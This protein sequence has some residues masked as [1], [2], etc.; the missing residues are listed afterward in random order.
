MRPMLQDLR[1]GLRM[2]VKQPGFTAIAA[3]TLALGI[4]ANTAI[5]SVVNAVL[6]KPLPFPQPERVIAV[7][8]IDARQKQTRLG[9]FSYPDFFDYRDQNHSLVGLAL[10]R[11]RNFALTNKAGATSLR[12]LKT[13]AE[14][15]DVLGITP[16]IGHGFSRTDEQA[17][18]GPGGFKVVLS[19]DF[20]QSQF[21]GDANVIGRTL[22]LDR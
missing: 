20:W 6:L 15:F 16:R 8:M 2:L 17:G 12:A 9:A 13:S 10:Y 1:Y 18:G 19:H 3:L 22:E 14:F 4:G 11:D 7:G 21:G 5:F